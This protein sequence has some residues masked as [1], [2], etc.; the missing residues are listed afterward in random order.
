MPFPA[1][2]ALSTIY[3][4]FLRAYYVAMW[5]MPHNSTPVVAKNLSSLEPRWTLLSIAVGVFFRCWASSGGRHVRYRLQMNTMGSSGANSPHIATACDIVSE[6]KLLFW[7]CGAD[8]GARD[9]ITFFYRSVRA[10]VPATLACASGRARVGGP[11]CR[12]GTATFQMPS[13][14][15]ASIRSDAYVADE[16]VRVR[17]VIRAYSESAVPYNEVAMRDTVTIVVPDPEHRDRVQ[18]LLHEVGD[19]VLSSCGDASSE[20]R[21]HDGFL[22]GTKDQCV[23]LVCQSVYC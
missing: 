16:C 11:C 4:L 13:P 3:F 14:R 22:R 12:A 7:C 6:R 9:E 19:H 18:S 20:H 5:D 8:L 1:T 15:N 17:V 10:R 21:D 2:S 23:L